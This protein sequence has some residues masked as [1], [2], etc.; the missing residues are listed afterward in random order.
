MENFKRETTDFLLIIVHIAGE[1]GSRS[2]N[3]L[4]K[5]TCDVIVFVPWLVK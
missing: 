1:G 5:I 4:E 2:G 3:E